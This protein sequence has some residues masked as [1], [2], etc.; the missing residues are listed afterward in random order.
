MADNLVI[1][2]SAAKVSTI[3]RFSL[4]ACTG[5]GVGA[6]AQGFIQGMR[7]GG[8]DGAH[9]LGIQFLLLGRKHAAADRCQADEE[10][11]D[12]PELLHFCYVSRRWLRWQVRF[13]GH[14]A[15]FGVEKHALR[16]YTALVI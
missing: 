11:K 15:L 5:V 9:E 6:S 8:F 7:I 4:A 12:K 10:Q 16:R 13:F 3:S 14:P 1:V 2:E